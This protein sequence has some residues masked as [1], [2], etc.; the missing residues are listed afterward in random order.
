[1][2]LK[3]IDILDPDIYVRD[4]PHTDFERLRREAPVFW[5]PEPDGPGFWA[6][7]KHEDVITVLKDAATFSSQVAGTQI[8]DVPEGDIRRSPDLLAIMDP[9]RHSRYRA[10]IGQSFTS[11][12]LSRSEEHIKAL[13]T[14]ILD[15]LIARREFDFIQDFAVRLPMAVILRMVGVPD[16]DHEKLSDWILRVLATDDPEYATTPEQR[17]MIGGKIMEYAH[18]LAAE[19]RST[20]RDD[21]LS[22]LMAAEVEGQKLTYGEF[23]MFFLL[24]LG[25]G[26][27][28]PLVLGSAMQ[29]M[30]QY[31]QERER[32]RQN[33]ALIES[34]V[35]EVIRCYPPFMHFRRTALRDTQ[36]RGQRIAAGQKVVTWL[37]SANRDA[38]VFERPHTF[39]VG[40]TVNPHVGFGHGPH[41]C[42][43]NALARRLTKVALAE[44]VRRLP[45]LELRG[46]VKRLR[47]NWYNGAKRMPVA[48]TPTAT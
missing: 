3:D 12:G 6:I 21:L 34:A 48:L 31:P 38:D 13:T 25:A 45:G 10:L 28:T 37:V 5:H 15:R 43:G 8:P 17:G 29:A 4:V 46:E 32:L 2:T 9:P 22:V 40:R 16:E 24:L 14:E 47:S 33:P 35:E 30:M 44:C 18:A 26:T 19:R 36:I 20:P 27:D 7:T 42:I 1:M 39:D 11:R 41:F 23:G